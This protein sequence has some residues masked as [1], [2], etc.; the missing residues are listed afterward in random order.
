MEKLNKLVYGIIIIN[1]LTAVLGKLFYALKL[2]Y[3][4][5]IVEVVL[6]LSLLC[7]VISYVYGVIKKV[8]IDNVFFFLSFVLFPCADVAFMSKTFNVS[9]TVC[10][11][12]LTANILISCGLL[13]YSGIYRFKNNEKSEKAEKDPVSSIMQNNRYFLLIISLCNISMLVNI[14]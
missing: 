7:L 14:L 8:R 6:G 12:L 4:I 9:Y 1:L 10:L 2:Q 5:Y 11:L 13:I 3:P